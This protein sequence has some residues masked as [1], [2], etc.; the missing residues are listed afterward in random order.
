[1]GTINNSGGLTEAVAANVY[2]VRYHAFPWDLIEPARTSPAT[3]QWSQVDETSLINAAA[4]DLETIAIVQ[5][6]PSWAQQFSGSA[7]GPIRIDHLDE[8]AQ[9]L[10]ALVN[11]YK[12]APYSVHYW[13]LGNEPDAPLVYSRQMWGCWGRTNDPYYGGQ[14]YGEMLKIAYPAIKAADPSA[15]VLVGGLLLDCDPNNPPAG[16]DCTMSKFLEG[17]LRAGGGPYFDAVSFHVYTYYGGSL[18]TMGTGNWPGSTT[19]I[20]Q[21]TSF[22]WDTLNRFGYGDKAL[23]NTEAALL[24]FTDS[25]Q[26]LDT[27]GMYIPRAYADAL[28]LNL[29]GQVYFSMKGTWYYSGLLEPDRTPK[30]VYYAYQAAADFLSD[31]DYVGPVTP[32]PGATRLAGYTF[33]KWDHQS[34]IDVVWTTDGLVEQVI[35]PEGAAA[36][37]RY[38]TPTTGLPYNWAGW[39]EASSAPLYVERPV[40]P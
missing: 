29:L 3:Y 13:E 25:A 35:L 8:F 14:A 5:Y 1:M 7:C 40:G 15:Q 11:R 24:C 34:Y 2:W 20:P 6:T 21:K 16:K 37:D 19:A 12:N 23:I 32:Y 9:F 39:I 22:I 31:V 33:E 26:C 30:P 17:I 18:G 4:N 38:G 36:Y 10:G 28:R 27:Q